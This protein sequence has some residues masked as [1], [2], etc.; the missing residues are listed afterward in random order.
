MQRPRSGKEYL[1]LD[2]KKYVTDFPVSGDDSVRTTPQSPITPSM[3][4]S[5]VFN[6]DLSQMGSHASFMSVYSSGDDSPKF[7]PSV[8]SR[9]SMGR[10]EPHTYVNL[11]FPKNESPRFMDTPPASPRCISKI[12]EQMN[13][14]LNYAEIDLS[15]T[16]TSKKSRKPRREGAIQY[17]MIDMIATVAAS[18]V[19][20]EHAKHREDSLRRKDNLRR[21][22]SDA[23]D[24]VRGGKERRSHM[25]SASGSKR[26]RA[27]MRSAS[28]ASSRDRKLS[29]SSFN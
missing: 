28:S 10:T 19:G 24:M 16:N 8:I 4:S 6:F 23:R 25:G 7:S 1:R 22:E 14:Q 26:E 20:R 18:K 13:P 9:Q 15:D 3:A 12:P 29:S 27:L 11:M 17:A 21:S 2:R 5:S